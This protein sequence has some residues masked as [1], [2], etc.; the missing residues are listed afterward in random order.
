MLPQLL[1]L[2]GEAPR[3]SPQAVALVRV[4]G[5][6]V[7]L[8]LDPA[9][10]GL[11]DG[12][13]LRVVR[14]AAA[15][16][17]PQVADVT[18]ATAE[19]LR[20][21]CGPMVGGHPPGGRRHGRRASRSPS[22]GI[23]ALAAPGRRDPRRSVWGSPRSSCWPRAPDWAEPG[24]AYAGLVLARA[25]PR[26]R[27]AVRA[28]AGREPPR[29]RPAR[30]SLLV[31]VALGAGIGVGRR[32]RGALAGA[33]AGALITGLHLALG[34]LVDAV[35][36]DAAVAVVAVVA[37]GLLPWWAMTS[38]GLTGLDDAALDGAAP[39]R[40][41]V[42]TTL[43]EAYRGLTWSAVAVAVAIAISCTGLV[44]SGDDGATLLAGIVLAVVALRTRSLPLRTQAV[45]LWVAVVIPLVVGVL[46]PWGAQEPWLAA[47]ITLGV[48]VLA[49][50][51]P[52]RVRP[53]SS[54]PG[55]AGSVT[56]RSWSACWPSCPSRSACSAS[57]A[58]S[59]ARSDARPRRAP[60]GVRRLDGGGPRPRGGRRGPAPPGVDQPADRGRAGARRCRGD[61]GD[62][63]GRLRARRSA[64]DRGAG[65]RRRPRRRVAGR[66][67]RDRPAARVG[68]RPRPDRGDRP[69]GPGARARSRRTRDGLRRRWA[70]GRRRHRGHRSRGRGAR[71]STPWAGSSTSSS[72]TGA[73]ARPDEL[74]VV[75]GDHHVVVVVARA[76]RADAERGVA[77]GDAPGDDRAAGARGRA[78]ARRRRAAPAGPSATPARD[79]LA[80]HAVTVRT[81]PYDPALGAGA[82]VAGDRGPHGVLDARRAPADAGVRPA[83]RPDRRGR[84]MT[85]TLVHRPARVVRPARPAA[86]R[87]G[88]RSRRR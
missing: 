88:R 20:I 53:V 61:D 49:A 14:A 85:R 21:P 68:R 78:P 57:T 16:P 1:E 84:G 63:R 62:R 36:A 19:E 22:A 54:G 24:S 35:H 52:A 15:P 2:L 12:E 27:G 40:T 28:A 17:P 59:W 31:W 39:Q 64:A 47:G 67:V 66:R 7:D 51:S 34:A 46:G 29:E 50:S 72:P 69:G 76:D 25:R 38:S 48:G 87:P 8:A 3:L 30:R 11:A 77:L 13:V 33:L 86:R 73:C 44:A 6:Q 37:C 71:S 4:S 18:D 10:Q 56:S 45:A 80:E 42:R 60:A 58:T 65:H 9:S 79:A 55:C 75:S 43:D 23:V 5:D 32:D 70:T 41:R 82:D 74:A 81:V 26:L 83:R